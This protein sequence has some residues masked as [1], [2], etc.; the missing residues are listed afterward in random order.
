V[1]A[2]GSKLQLTAAN[3]ESWALI[4]P[5]GG[6]RLVDYAAQFVVPGDTHREEMSREVA[7]RAGSRAKLHSL[8]A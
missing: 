8:P 4:K 7:W 6:W 1:V 5:D 2:R 3:P